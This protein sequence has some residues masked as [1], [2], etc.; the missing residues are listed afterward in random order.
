MSADDLSNF[1]MMD[2]FRAEVE[3]HVA[4]LNASLLDLERDPS[5]KSLLESL[6]RAAHSIKGAAR[7]VQ[8]D[9]GV[10]VAHALED[11]FVAAQSGKVGLRPDHMDV[12]LSC[13]DLLGR[14]AG[15]NEADLQ[16]WQAANIPEITQ[17]ISAVGAITSGASAQNPSSGEAGVP[18]RQLRARR[19]PDAAG[20]GG[21]SFHIFGADCSCGCWKSKSFDG[22]GG[23][24][25]DCGW[26]T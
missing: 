2:L 14:M 19:H 26:G 17:C 20:H 8:F 5:S 10:R 21:P 4:V 16:E 13:V 1:S 24:S 23:R 9:S 7:I 6:M 11:C 12:L 18:A 25:D 22:A 3:T 15:V